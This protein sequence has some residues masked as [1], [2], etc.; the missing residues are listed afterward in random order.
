VSSPFGT[1]STSTG[2]SP[3]YLGGK[4]VLFESAGDSALSVATIVR[5]APPSGSDEFRTEQ[6]T[7]DVRV[8]ADWQFTPTLSLNP[9]VG[10]AEYEDS[11][12]RFGTAL[13]ALTLSWQPTPKW[14]PFVDVAYQSREEREGTWAM[15]VDAGVSYLVACDLALDL[16]AGQ[17]VHGFTSPKPFVAAG[18]SVRVDLLHRSTQPLDHLHGARPTR[19]SRL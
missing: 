4:V 19:S 5:V 17:N 18:I 9:N 3:L 13:G 16:S 2:L 10:W 12:E 7:G 15:I 11:G 8:V 14:N 6:T 1:V